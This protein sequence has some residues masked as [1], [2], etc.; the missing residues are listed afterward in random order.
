MTK[1]E[2]S[3][4]RFNSNFPTPGSLPPAKKGLPIADEKP[5]NHV[6]L[7]YD[8]KKVLARHFLAK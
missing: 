1:I 5:Q 2:K 8:W 3:K 7:V 4:T 6:R